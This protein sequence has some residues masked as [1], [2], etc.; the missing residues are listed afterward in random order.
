MAGC[1][2]YKIRSPGVLELEETCEEII[3]SDLFM[4]YFGLDGDSL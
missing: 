4:S 3:L 1:D 2:R